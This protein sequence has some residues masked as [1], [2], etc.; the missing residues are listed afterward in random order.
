MSWVYS[1]FRMQADGSGLESHGLQRFGLWQHYNK[2]HDNVGP[3]ASTSQ[4]V[5]FGK[6]KGKE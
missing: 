5:S 4:E 2:K 6:K 1:Y 3:S